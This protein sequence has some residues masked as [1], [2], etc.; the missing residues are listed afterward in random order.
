MNL[1]KQNVLMFEKT[2]NLGGSSKIVIQMCEALKPKVNKIVVCSVGGLNT[3]ALDELGIK[4]YNIPDISNLTFSNMFRTLSVLNKVIKHENITIIHTH[5][6]MAAFYTFILSFFKDFSFLASVHGEFYDKKIFTKMAY[7][8]ALVIPCGDMVKKNIIDFFG[9][10]KNIV[11]LRN[12]IR[13]DLSPV[14]EIP[15]LQEYKKN[16]YKLIGYLGRLS[17]EKGVLY[18]IDSLKFFAEDEK[19]RYVIV[20]EGYM[21]DKM[22]QILA[23]NHCE[24]KVIYLGYRNDPQNV[25]RQLDCV[26]LPSLTEGLPLTPM[27]AFAQGK[28]VIASAVGG[29]VELVRNGENGILI[30]PRKSKEIAIAIR[31]L[32]FNRELYN[33]CVENAKIDYETKFSIEV[34]NKDLEKI[35]EGLK[36]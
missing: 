28:P 4:H 8:R 16:N 20:G 2:M 22:D 14:K 17:E 7:S 1:K 19:I 27:E 13:K 35:Y 29:N 33:S 30:S 24:N 6:R 36:E 26:V 5:H 23:R 34:F 15:E 10:K 21:K 9:V 11:V 12:A 25:I 31:Q 32:L 3:S 18:L